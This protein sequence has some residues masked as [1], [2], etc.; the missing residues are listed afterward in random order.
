[1]LNYRGLSAATLACIV[2][3]CLMTG[4]PLRADTIISTNFST[5][6]PPY[7]P[8]TGDAWGTGGGADSENAVGFTSPFSTPYLLSQILVPD[9]FAQNS[10]D[11]GVYNDLNVGIWVN[12]TNNLNGATE[13]QSWSISPSGSAPQSP[14]L[15]T[16]TSATTTL[17][18]P[19][20]FYFV[21]E[22]VLADPGGT[23]A[24]WGWQ[25]NNLSPVEDGYYS[26]FPGPDASWFEET[27]AT[28]A[29]EVTGN[30][31]VASTVPEPRAYA[32]LLAAVFATLLTFRLRKFKNSGRRA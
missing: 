12:T 14:Q 2:G 11:G 13:L 20:D 7:D 17:I 31:Y 8:S 18:N 32:F 9:N 29:F 28:P 5:S 27:G 16:L 24:E 4:L 10:T 21:T 6:N 15:Y 3:G 22:S 23:T 1:M 19:G 30:P 26:Y 25:Q